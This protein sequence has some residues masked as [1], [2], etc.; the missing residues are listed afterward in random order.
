MSKKKTDPDATPPSAAVT[1]PQRKGPG[2]RLCSIGR[3]HELVAEVASAT[4]DA[5]G[6]V[7]HKGRRCYVE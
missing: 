3:P 1:P 4:P 2:V 6:V 7:T 5:Q